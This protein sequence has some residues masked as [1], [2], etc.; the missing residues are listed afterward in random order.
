MWR[1]VFLV[2]QYAKVRSSLPVFHGE[3]YRCLAELKINIRT[4]NYI[5][6]KNSVFYLNYYRPYL[7]EYK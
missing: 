7:S 1:H 2:T 3:K 6:I 5:N 4:V